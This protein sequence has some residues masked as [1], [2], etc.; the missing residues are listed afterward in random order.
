M[1]FIDKTMDAWNKMT[2]RLSPGLSKTRQVTSKTANTLISA[3]KYISKFRKVF[4]AVPVGTMAVILALQNIV[5]LPVVV[6]LDLQSN[7]EFTIQIAR[8]I[9]ALG[10]MAITALCLLLMFC[11]KRTLTPW[12][13]SV[14]SLLLP[15]LILLT[16]TFPA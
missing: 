12:L 16:N 6:G 5:K 9:A 15:L 14:F 10:P 2:A 3:W 1:N 7:G 4:L 13:V 11:S 8:E